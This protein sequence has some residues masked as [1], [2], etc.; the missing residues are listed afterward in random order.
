MINSYAKLVCINLIVVGK[1][2]Y[3]HTF[4]FLPYFFTKLQSVIKLKYIFGSSIEESVE[5]NL[6]ERSLNANRPYQSFL[7]YIVYTCRFSFRVSFNNKVA[8]YIL[9]FFLSNL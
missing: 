2:I 7:L 6:F 1:I 8:I 4:F 9:F 3:N 5:I